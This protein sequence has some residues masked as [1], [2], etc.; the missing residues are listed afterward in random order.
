LIAPTKTLSRHPGYRASAKLSAS[1][2]DILRS[3]IAQG[4]EDAA[5][6]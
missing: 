2:F 6:A 1:A 4:R 5:L 3:G